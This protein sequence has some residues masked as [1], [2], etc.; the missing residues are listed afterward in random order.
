M[1]LRGIE[2]YC[3]EPQRSSGS[4]RS[5]PSRKLDPRVAVLQS[6]L[7]QRHRTAG[8]LFSAADANRDNKAGGPAGRR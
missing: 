7:R 3:D 8:E 1:P 5:D 4:R 2:A 6:Q